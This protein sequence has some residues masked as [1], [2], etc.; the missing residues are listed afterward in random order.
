MAPPYL[1][2][3]SP[4]ADIVQPIDGV[5]AKTIG[6]I[7]DLFFFKYRFR[8]LRQFLHIHKPLFHRQWFNDRSAFI[9]V[10]N[11]VLMVLY[12]YQQIGFFQ[13]FDN[14]LATCIA[15]KSSKT[16]RRRRHDSVETDYLNLLELMSLTDFIVVW[17]VGWRH[18]DCTTTHFRV[19]IFIGDNGDC[20]VHQGQ[21][22]LLA[23]RV[24]PSC[25]TG[26]HDYRRITEHSFGTCG[27]DD[28]IGATIFA[29][30]ANMPQMPRQLALFGFEI[31]DYRPALRTPVNH[32]S[33][34]IYP[35]L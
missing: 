3:K 15:V 23:N 19:G 10:R 25:V 27:R 35:T 9:V 22:D 5:L 34:A 13:G 4:I 7:V 26:M 30:V 17:I 31:G 14:S 6:H 2:R 16:P 20:P 24:G 21:F 33:P 12:L 8:F 28:H 18:L 1:P 32:P 11:R 29:R